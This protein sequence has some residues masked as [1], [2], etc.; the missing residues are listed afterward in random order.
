MREALSSYKTCSEKKCP[1]CSW[2]RASGTHRKPYAIVVCFPVDASRYRG[3][4][5]AVRQCSTGFQRDPPAPA[6]PPW[7]TDLACPSHFGLGGCGVPRPHFHFTCYF[8]NPT[9][10]GVVPAPPLPEDRRGSRWAEVAHTEADKSLKAPIFDI[11]SAVSTARSLYVHRPPVRT[12]FATHRHT[13]SHSAIGH[14]GSKRHP[15]TAVTQAPRPTAEINPFR[16]ISI[17]RLPP[18][19]PIEL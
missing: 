5:D 1:K 15:E 16:Y 7:P 14:C 11:A 12:W 13:P 10:P 3:P 2:P 4:A 6:D 17:E 19:Q 9:K 8:P 18:L